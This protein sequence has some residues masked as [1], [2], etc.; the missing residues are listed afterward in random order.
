MPP[1]A[2]WIVTFFVPKFTASLVPM[3]MAPVPVVF[4][5]TRLPA[6]M[7]PIWVLVMM[8]VL[9]LVPTPMVV[10]SNFG[11]MVTVLVPALIVVA[12]VKVEPTL[13]RMSAPLEVN[14][15]PAARVTVA[16]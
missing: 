2:C 11:W 14:G 10:A 5:M 15:A 8:S 3:L 4:P 13:M 7:L 9:V 12:S 6:V 16:V 1:V